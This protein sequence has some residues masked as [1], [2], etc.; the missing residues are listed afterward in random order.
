[1]RGDAPGDNYAGMGQDEMNASFGRNSGRGSRRENYYKFKRQDSAESYKLNELIRKSGDGNIRDQAGNR[2]A[3]RNHQGRNNDYK[4][5]DDVPG[6]PKNY[7]NTSNPPPGNDYDYAQRNNYHRD[8]YGS[9]APQNGRTVERMGSGM[10]I[11][12]P[13]QVGGNFHQRHKSTVP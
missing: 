6:K 10:Q 12:K 3:G 13:Q 2:R 4:T 9:P 5:I 8:G 1:M 11:D 7:K